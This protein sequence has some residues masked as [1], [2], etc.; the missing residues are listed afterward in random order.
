M[1]SLRWLIGLPLVVCCAPSPAAPGRPADTAPTPSALASSWTTVPTPPRQEA[2]VS[3]TFSGPSTSVVT[4]PGPRLSGVL[5]CSQRPGPDTR[6]PTDRD[7]DGVPED[8]DRCPDDPQKDAQRGSSGCNVIK[9]HLV[10]HSFQVEL[11]FAT[12]STRFTPDDRDL[13]QSVGRHYRQAVLLDHQG[14]YLDLQIHTKEARPDRRGLLDRRLQ[15]TREA[16]LR[17]GVEPSHLRV[18]PPKV[19][20]PTEAEGE[21]IRVFPAGMEIPHHTE[22]IWLR[23]EPAI[24]LSPCENNLL[25]PEP[26]EAHLGL[27]QVVNGSTRWPAIVVTNQGQETTTSLQLFHK[28]R[29]VGWVRALAP[30]ESAFLPL[31][32]ERVPVERKVSAQEVPGWL[33]G[34]TPRG[35][36]HI[37]F[38]TTTR[39]HWELPS[40]EASRFQG[41]AHPRRRGFQL[42]GSPTNGLVLPHVVV[43]P[44]GP[45]GRTEQVVE[46]GLER[47]WENLG[48]LPAEQL[49]QLADANPPQAVF[50]RE[51]AILARTETRTRTAL[52]QAVRS[53]AP[54]GAMTRL[55]REARLARVAVFERIRSAPPLVNPVP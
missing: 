50:L 31:E 26:R 43:L 48:N 13:I 24:D 7:G 47:R 17:Q 18:L 8:V 51:L 19:N 12:S 25:T 11:V 2:Q 15:A 20:A 33:L 37:D 55:A 36:A 10:A 35:H 4:R 54:S 28:L 1:A 32:G 27:Q 52:E 53:S 14:A 44:L 45:D 42:L 6:D 30:G 22:E 23:E 34:F 21:V 29:P 49:E 40:T 39:T 5:P 41:V 16:L 9:S 46:R 3:L 38:V